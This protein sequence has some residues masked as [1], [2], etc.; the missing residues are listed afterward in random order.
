M[1]A[2]SRGSAAIGFVLAL[3]FGALTG[4]VE[5]ATQPQALTPWDAQLYAA[6]FA[7]ADRGEF[8]EASAKLA[9]TS[10]KL[11][12]GHVDF[13]R[14][15]APK[16]HKASYEELS[17]WLEQNADHPEADRVYAL[18]KKRKP[19]GALDL[20]API[21]S[22]GSF[23]IRRVF[24]N[25][26]G[27]SDH[28]RPQPVTPDG[29]SAR[30][31]F[32]SGETEKALGLAEAAGERWIAGLSAFRLGRYGDA[33]RR[34][35]LVARDEGEGAWIRSGA[36]YWAARSA[37]AS[38]S[39]ELAPDYLRMAARTPHT[40]YGQ[41][42]ERQ[43]GLKSDIS[44]EEARDPIRELVEADSGIQRIAGVDEFALAK[45]MRDEPRAKRAAALS[46]LGLTEECG[47]EL[48]A[49][50][51]SA[52]SDAARRDWTTLALTLNTS[53]A[54]GGDI[55][56]PKGVSPDDFP[57]PA[58]NPRGGYNLDRSLVYAIIRQESRFNASAKSPAGARGLMQVM[59]ATA[60]YVAGDDKLKADPRA[61]HDPAVNLRIGQDY[62]RKLLDQLSP[63]DDLL[64]SVAAYN[65]GPGAV[66]RAVQTSGGD[67]DALMLIESLPAQETRDYVEKV[68]AGYWIYR[69]IFGE[70]A[71]TLDAVASGH[72][73]A[74]LKLDR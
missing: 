73:S 28:G 49:G 35:E 4:Q 31:A 69:R 25:P 13:M 36:A 52:K 44:G 63:S 50:L 68:V 32:Y 20:K 70:D 48:R 33:L 23:N 65:G 55:R 11:L 19:A 8:D 3:S 43:L 66:M 29:R 51:L 45:F 74:D 57:T 7:A 39:P 59:P 17:A 62:F 40:F 26:F 72:R 18:A 16:G 71:P 12:A 6:A 22:L 37:M 27:A 41:I 24:A 54:T 9:Q 53:I 21:L 10:D 64:R 56:K 61:L 42:A 5:A 60:A 30:E 14:L 34:F 58:L 38:G 15:M 67:Q 46:Q 47:R 2:F 1:R